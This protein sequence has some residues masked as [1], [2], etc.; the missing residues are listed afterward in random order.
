MVVLGRG[1]SAQPRRGFGV[2]HIGTIITVYCVVLFYRSMSH[3]R[4]DVAA[5]TASIQGSGILSDVG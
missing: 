5:I 1:L 4:I 2:I 3:I